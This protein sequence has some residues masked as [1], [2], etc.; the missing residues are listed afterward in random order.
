MHPPTH[1]T[2]PPTRAGVSLLLQPS[3]TWGPIGQLHAWD[4]AVR[5]VENGFAL[6]RCSSGGL[7]G[8]WD[9]TYTPHMLSYTTLSSPFFLQATVPRPAARPTLYPWVGFV[10]GW[11]CLAVACGYVIV[12]VGPGDKAMRVAAS[13]FRRGVGGG[14]GGGGKK[15]EKKRG[16][17]D[18]LLP[19]E[20]GGGKI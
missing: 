6:F 16:E 12:I 19:R 8:Y 1:P 14:G 2:H 10:F 20:G 9:A 13:R 7:S 18:A 15:E 11:L 5:G 17:R 3:W 4:S